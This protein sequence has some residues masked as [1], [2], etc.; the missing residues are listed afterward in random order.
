MVATALTPLENDPKYKAALKTIADLQ[1]PVL[2]NISQSIKAT[3]I[4][5]LPAIKNVKVQIAAA[6]RVRALRRSSE[7]VVDDGSATPLKHKGDGVQSLAAIAL[8]RR[9]AAQQSAANYSVIALEEPESHLHPKAIHELRVVLQELATTQQIVITTHCPVFVDR[10]HI[11]A[12]LIVDRN[13]ARSARSI[14]EIRDIL[15]V[16]AADNLRHAELVLVVE[17]TED[18]VALGALLPANSSIVGGALESGTLVINALQG[19][20]NL[21]Y[22]I[23]LL[24][25]ALCEYHCYLD[26]DD[27]GRRSL[28]AARNDGLLRDAEYNL[29]ICNGMTQ[30]EIEDIYALQTYRAAVENA[31]TV[32]MDVPGFHGNA[33]WSDRLREI[34]L[35]QGKEW[36]DR[37]KADV[38]M[39]VA[40]A[41]ADAPGAALNFHKRSSFDGLVNALEKRLASL[42][43]RV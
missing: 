41:V 17:G 28:D 7:I 24:R 8:M 14:A 42:Q 27:A 13:R 29:T 35:S 16:R 34:F 39:L 23:S 32:N 3:L 10:M 31:H 12:N 4:Q 38:K 9:A 40:K 25:D 37:V 22:K 2:D 30:A 36:N 11:G 19:A 43:R 6:D 21:S 15:G 33:K 26:N 1:K 5:F 18:V 20:T